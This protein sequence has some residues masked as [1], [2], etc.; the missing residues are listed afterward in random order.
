MLNKEI[1]KTAVNSWKVEEEHTVLE[2]VVYNALRGKPLGRGFTSITNQNKIVSNANDPDY[3]LNEAKR[4]LF[5]RLGGR[6]YGYNEQ[7][8]AHLSKLFGVE[9]DDD[10]KSFLL[11]L[12][13]V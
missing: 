4:E 9:F 10:L 13:K 5:Y 1:I 3:A 6:K 11:D 2:H 8:V 12:L 7:Y